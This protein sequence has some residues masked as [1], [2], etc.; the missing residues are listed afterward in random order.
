MAASN[1]ML[2]FYLKAALGL[3]VCQLPPQ[4]KSDE[5][6]LPMCVMLQDMSLHQQKE[7]GLVAQ[8]NLFYFVDCLIAKFSSDFKGKRI[9]YP[10]TF[11]LH[12]TSRY[13]SRM[14]MTV[15]Y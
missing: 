1:H 13:T 9:T 15:N 10:F 6:L 3:A 5:E 12:Q 14:E 7:L 8:I 2:A 4:G 11:E